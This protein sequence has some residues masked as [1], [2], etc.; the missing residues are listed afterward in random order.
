[1]MV[2]STLLMFVFAKPDIKLWYMNALL[3]S[4]EEES[5]WGH[6]ATDN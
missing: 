5:F 6:K 2:K 1:M 3:I 4:P